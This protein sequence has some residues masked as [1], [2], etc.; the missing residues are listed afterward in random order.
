M[1][2]RT[3]GLLIVAGAAFV[4]ACADDD[5]PASAPIIRE[6]I[7]ALT[8]GEEVPT[9]TGVSSSGE[10]R[11]TVRTERNLSTGALDTAAVLVE[12]VVQNID[13]VTA[14]HIHAGA[15]GVAGPIMVFL[16]PTAGFPLV[17]GQRVARH[18]PDSSTMLNG[19]LSYVAITR[20]TAFQAGWTYD[21]LLA[22]INNGTAYVNVHTRR[23][24]PGEIRGQID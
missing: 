16:T 6:F 9:V 3:K 18:L 13:S 19:T 8:P 21:S 1:T 23:N 2:S 17:R 10:S 11:I 20:G 15:P 4:W 14:A 5:V 7:V 24:A 12:T 22:R